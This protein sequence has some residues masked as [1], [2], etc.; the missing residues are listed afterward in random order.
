MHFVA[1][2]FESN[3]ELAAEMRVGLHHAP[4]RRG[5]ARAAAAAHVDQRLA[6]RGSTFTQ[7]SPGV[8]VGQPADACRLA[9]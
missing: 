3:L 6:E 7:Q 4:P 1:Q 2:A 9:Q 8:A 5:E